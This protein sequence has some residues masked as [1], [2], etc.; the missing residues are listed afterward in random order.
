MV[1]KLAQFLMDENKNLD[2][3]HKHYVESASV[4]KA[5]VEKEREKQ[6]EKKTFL[7]LLKEKLL[8]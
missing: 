7:S 6:I 5:I 3:K 8:K 1:L 2:E 4:A